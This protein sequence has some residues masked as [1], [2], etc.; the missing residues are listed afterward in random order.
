MVPRTTLSFYR[1]V[2]LED[3]WAFRGEL[4]R[5]WSA[6]GVFGR[7]YLAHEGV[8]AQVS[9]PTALLHAFRNILNAIPEFTGVP[10]K[11]AVEENGRS[12]RKL[13]IK[14]KPK[15]VADGL[16]DGTFDS[17]NV[18]EHLD[19]GTFDL[20][21]QDGATV[22][23]MRNNYE[24]AIGHFEGAYLPRSGTFR[25]VLHEVTD[26]M[27]G[28]RQESILLYCTGGIRCEKASAWL[29][30]QGF[31]NV[32]QLHGGIIDYV[33][34]VRAQGRESRFKGRN[35]VFD[36][37][38]SERITDDLL[39]TC[40]QCGQ[41]TDRIANCMEES[42]NLLLVQCPQCAAKY[43]D[44]CSPSC[45]EIHL[46]PVEAQ[47]EWRKG[48]VTRSTITKA[49]TNAQ[50]HQELIREQEA[51]LALNGTLHPELSDVT[52]KVIPAS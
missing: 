50:A 14:V 19:A 29:R 32:C 22:V 48:R 4:L 44:C 35:F 42:C 12:F 13:T 1:Y 15:L 10:L 18:G 23:D 33:R 2:R 5:Q 16:P 8:N 39:G 21:H 40:V 20:L 28:R 49:V 37:R 47:R 27:A 36:D 17:T 3:P 43:A 38:L 41:A 52:R 25:D 26:A 11:I 51:A 31:S 24:C 46:L 45:R 6:L 34:Q 7:T 9:L 30:H